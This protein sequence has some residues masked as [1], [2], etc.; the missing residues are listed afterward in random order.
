MTEK[1][2]LI[3]TPIYYDNGKIAYTPEQ[4]KLVVDDYLRKAEKSIDRAR[5]R[6]KYAPGVKRPMIQPTPEEEFVMEVQEKGDYNWIVSVVLSRNQLD[7]IRALRTQMYTIVPGGSTID[8]MIKHIN[9]VFRDTN[10]SYIDRAR[11]KDYLKF[12][13]DLSK[14]F[15]AANLAQDSQP[16][17]AVAVAVQTGTDKTDAKAQ[18]IDVPVK[19]LKRVKDTEAV[20]Q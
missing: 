7:P 1:K 10:S 20:E 17:V 12:I 15:N 18:I 4:I 2:E 5:S 3:Y 9:D 19:G 16:N 13:D 8:I 6:S 11:A 14:K